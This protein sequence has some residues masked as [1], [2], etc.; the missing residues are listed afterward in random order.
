MLMD[1]AVEV[2]RR[3]QDWTSAAAIAAIALFQLVDKPGIER[4]ILGGGLVSLLLVVFIAATDRVA[5]LFLLLRGVKY[6]Q[7]TVTWTSLPPLSRLPWLRKARY[8]AFYLHT[9]SLMIGLT[10]IVLAAL[11]IDVA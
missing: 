10:L 4:L 3:F 1:A 6:A 8:W 2:R 5:E 9:I 7:Q 11:T